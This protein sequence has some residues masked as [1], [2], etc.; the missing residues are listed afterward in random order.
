CPNS[1][2]QV[3]IE[4]ATGW[5][6]L[7]HSGIHNHVAPTSKNANLIAMKVLTAQLVKNSKAGPLVLKV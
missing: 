5:G 2:C 3:N 4:K 1:N 7:C 6:V